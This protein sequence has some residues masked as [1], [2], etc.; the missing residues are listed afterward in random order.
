MQWV[1]TR[2]AFGEGEEASDQG[3]TGHQTKLPDTV[4]V[5]SRA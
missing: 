5:V 2:A 4:Y 3:K 1:L